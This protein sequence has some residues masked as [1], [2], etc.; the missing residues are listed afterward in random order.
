[1]MQETEIETESAESE[2]EKVKHVGTDPE[3]GT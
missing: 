1:M 3:C 2:V